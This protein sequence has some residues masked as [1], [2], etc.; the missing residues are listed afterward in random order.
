MRTFLPL[1]LAILA[2]L[3]TGPGHAWMHGG[4]LV[5]FEGVELHG[6]DCDHFPGTEGHDEDC[7]CHASS[8]LVLLCSDAP[9]ETGRNEWQQV[10]RA[11]SWLAPAPA[12][13]TTR[14]RGPRAPPRER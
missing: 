2:T 12:A 11:A 8:R 6:E 14:V 3:A 9:V 10:G 7:V 5:T 4:D 13:W 1:L